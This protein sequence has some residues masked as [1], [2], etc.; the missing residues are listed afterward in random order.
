[1]GVQATV[2]AIIHRVFNITSA[3]ETA[4]KAG[5]VRSEAKSRA[6]HANGTKGGR[7]KKSQLATA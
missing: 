3:V 4:R 5:S 2:L 1:L 6:A 7:P